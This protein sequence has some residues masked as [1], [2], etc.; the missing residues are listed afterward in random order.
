M[1]K[2]KN[3]VLTLG[4]TRRKPRGLRV[5]VSGNDETY[6][7]PRMDQL[8]MGELMTLN[9]AVGADATDNMALT[10]FFYDLACRYIPKEH[11]DELSSEELGRLAVA[12]S[13]YGGDEGKSSASSA[14]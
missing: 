13:T 6:R 3:D 4:G 12:W 2:K 7:L 8:S 9:E 14:Q 1:A 10:R 5:R 11:V